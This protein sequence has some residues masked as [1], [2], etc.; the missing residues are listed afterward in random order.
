MIKEIFVIAVLGLCFA[1]AFQLYTNDW[2]FNAAFG[3]VTATVGTAVSGFT[4][5]LQ[6]NPMG[7][8]LAVGT[9][10]AAVVPF[11]KL[12]YDGLKKESAEKIENLDH[13]V[14]DKNTELTAVKETYTNQITD[15]ESQIETLKLENP[16]LTLLKDQ[17]LDSQNMETKLRSQLQGQ[18][19]M[20]TA[21]INDLTKG[22][23]EVID[24]QTNQVIKLVTLIKPKVL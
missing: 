2:D 20:H 23:K 16:D 17:L 9:G 4:T 5:S 18:E 8:L 21:F 13:L 15:L 12:A 14:V 22:A 11:A 6:E 10:A 19:N 7:T 1:A 24:P 3:G